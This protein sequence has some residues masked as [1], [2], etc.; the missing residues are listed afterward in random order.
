MD[1]RS[2]QSMAL[3]LTPRSLPGHGGAAPRGLPT[4]PWRLPQI[5]WLAVTVFAAN[6][7]PLLAEPPGIKA[8]VPQAE[9]IGNPQ[10]S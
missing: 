2:R 8:L 9:E 6:L 4:R 5:G 10:V 3:P 1:Y 7:V